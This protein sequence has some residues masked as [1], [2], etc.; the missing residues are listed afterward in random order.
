MIE[1]VYYKADV[2]RRHERWWRKN[3]WCVR[4]TERYRGATVTHRLNKTFRGPTRNDV[5]LDALE[6]AGEKEHKRQQRNLGVE[7][8]TIYPDLYGGKL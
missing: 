6:W 8:I 3:L 2:W 5:V 1:D 7:S 4:I